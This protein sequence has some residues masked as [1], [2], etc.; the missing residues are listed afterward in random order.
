MCCAYLRIFCAYFRFFQDCAYLRIFAHI[1]RIFC[2][3]S[4]KTH[5]NNS[6]RM[7]IFGPPKI[8]GPLKRPNFFRKIKKLPWGYLKWSALLSDQKYHHIL[9]QKSMGDEIWPTPILRF[10]HILRIF[11]HICAYFAHI[12]W[13]FGEKKGP[14][15]EGDPENFYGRSRM[16]TQ[17]IM[18]F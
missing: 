16:L 1:L 7:N 5:Q 3:F 13:I 18:K 2:N 8:F 11:A 17:K 9:K 6:L 10:A 14:F 12:F 4:G 15:S